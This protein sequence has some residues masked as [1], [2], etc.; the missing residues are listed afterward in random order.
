MFYLV[1]G[2]ET[3]KVTARVVMTVAIVGSNIIFL[4]NSSWTFGREFIKDVKKKRGEGI[5]LMTMK[6]LYIL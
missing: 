4:V 1:P 3:A 5:Q 2:E 6:K